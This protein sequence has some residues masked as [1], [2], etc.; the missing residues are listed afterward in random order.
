MSYVDNP[1]QWSVPKVGFDPTLSDSTEG[2]DSE[3]PGKDPGDPT[4]SDHL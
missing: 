3:E 4:N 2:S 1:E